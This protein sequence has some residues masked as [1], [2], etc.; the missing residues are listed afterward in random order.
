MLECHMEESKRWEALFLHCVVPVSHSP[1][2]SAQTL[3]KETL[4]HG[5]AIRV[6][7]VYFLE[8]ALWLLLV[9]Q[10]SPHVFGDI[11]HSNSSE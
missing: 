4:S 7:P 2:F 10:D 5:P 11:L 8:W 1:A 3:A 9:S 6:S